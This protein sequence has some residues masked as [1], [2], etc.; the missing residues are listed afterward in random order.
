MTLA[1]SEDFGA[2]D[3]DGSGERKIHDHQF[4]SANTAIPHLVGL[5][6]EA[7][8][9]HREFVKGVMR[10]DLFGI[11]EGGT[12][13]GRLIAPLRPDVPALEPGKRYLLEVVVRTLK[14][15][16]FFTQGT[17]DSNEVWLDVSLSSADRMLGRSGGLDPQDRSVDSWSH[18]VNAFVLDRHGQRI[19]RR[20]AEDIFIP[21]YDH[22]IP[23]GA[24]DVVHYAFDVPADQVEPLEVEVKLQYR[25]FDTLYMRQFQGDRFVTND[26]P[27]MTMA[28]DRL[29]FPIAGG[30][31]V[32]PQPGGD[33]PLWQR[34]NDYGIG[35]LLKG[36][37]GKNRGELRQAAD[38]FTRVAELGRGEGEVNLAR[39]Y[40]KEGDLP[41]AAEALHRASLGQQPAPAWSVAW[42]TALV[43]K[44]NGYLDEAIDNMRAILAMKDTEECRRRQLDFTR[45]YRL[46]VELGQTLYERSKRYRGDAQQAQRRQALLEARSWFEQ[47]LALDPENVSAHYNMALVCTE[48]GEPELAARHHALHEKY[49]P[50][51]NAR[52]QAIAAARMRYPAANHAAEDIV[53]YDLQRPG[54]F[55][56]QDQAA[57]QRGSGARGGSGQE[58]SGTQ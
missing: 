22:Q 45:D 47:A 25:K 12:I 40:L 35:L 15:G 43:N 27:I 4:P 33:F 29:T 31:A 57:A 58:S 2:K 36:D 16:H 53:I 56:I 11:K 20:N 50:D 46:L 55:E 1:A 9:A 24:A 3:Y 32:A 7:V 14:M 38:A 28:E 54:A 8:D 37:R 52:D 18:F 51:D 39:V 23:P 17:A 44:Q 42:F 48:L 49:K 41:P 13:D 34:W 10:V 30:P 19:D 6:P 26:L 21:L 5:P